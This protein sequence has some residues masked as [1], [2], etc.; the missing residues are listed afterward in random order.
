MGWEPATA[1]AI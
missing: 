1:F